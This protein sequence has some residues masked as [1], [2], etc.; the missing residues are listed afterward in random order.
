MESVA[1]RIL[2]DYRRAHTLTLP[3]RNKPGNVVS[4]A[5]IHLTIL[6]PHANY[7]TLPTYKPTRLCW[8]GF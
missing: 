4:T 8:S 5:L 3:T 6:P 2:P 7:S 1:S